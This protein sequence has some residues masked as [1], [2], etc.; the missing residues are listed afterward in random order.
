[1]AVR[2]FRI[3][4][5]TEIIVLKFLYCIESELWVAITVEFHMV[6]AYGLTTKYSTL[7]NTWLSTRFLYGSAVP[8]FSHKKKK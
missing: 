1:M 4:V 2:W 6:F 7:Q 3:L 5:I 8:H